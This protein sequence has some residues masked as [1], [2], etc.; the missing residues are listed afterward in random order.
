MPE[1]K[2]RILLIED[3][4]YL[5]KIYSNKLLQS[6]Y[7]VD[8]SINAE[9]GLR[10]VS[11]HKPDIILLDLILP[12]K[13][14]FEFMQDLKTMLG[15]NKKIPIIILSNLGQAI[16]MEQAKRLGAVDYLIKANVSLE[17]IVSKVKEVISPS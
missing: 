11:V 9:E 14:G 6:G 4:R 7:D 3:D 16:D 10:K 5:V 17:D 15:K 13:D 1:K 8:F 12:G 2:Q